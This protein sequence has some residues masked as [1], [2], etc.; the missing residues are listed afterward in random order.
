MC[1]FQISLYCMFFVIVLNRLVNGESQHSKL[2][3][4]AQ[5]LIDECFGCVSNT[6]T[7]CGDAVV[8]FLRKCNILSALASAF[9]W[10]K[11]TNC[12]QRSSTYYLPIFHSIF[13]VT[14][15]NAIIWIAKTNIRTVVNEVVL[16]VAEVKINI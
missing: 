7:N 11:L 5:R 1:A 9:Y 13:F 6:P 12:F 4:K 10:W 2:F 15:I 16:V 3:R 14:S 8:N